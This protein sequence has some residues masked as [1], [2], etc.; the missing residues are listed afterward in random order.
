[1]TG[2]RTP[3]LH[4]LVRDN[5]RRTTSVSS[6]TVDAQPVHGLATQYCLVSAGVFGEDQAQ[7]DL[8]IADA[9]NQDELRY[10]S[11]TVI[12]LLT[13]DGVPVCVMKVD[14]TIMTS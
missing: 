4:D 9:R 5:Y 2:A 8:S 14:P 12:H 11:Y 3:G 6:P 7:P 13:A 10:P 1:L